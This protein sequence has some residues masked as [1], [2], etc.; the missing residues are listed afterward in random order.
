MQTGLAL[1]L[2]D[3]CDRASPQRH[4]HPSGDIHNGVTDTIGLLITQTLI[5]HKGHRFETQYCG[6]ILSANTTLY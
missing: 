1:V 4:V 6:P 5:G 2:S 3:S